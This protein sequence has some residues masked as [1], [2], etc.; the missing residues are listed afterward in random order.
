MGSQQ[1]RFQAVPVSKPRNYGV[2][3]GHDVLIACLGISLLFC[4]CEPE[5]ATG[6]ISSSNE[7]FTR[8]TK[9]VPKGTAIATAQ[10]FMEKE[11]FV[12]EPLT[13]AKWKGKEGFDYILCKR[14]DG[15]PRMKRLR[16]VAI[17][18][19]GKKVT[20]VDSRMPI[21]FP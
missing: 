13:K 12:C 11:G 9:L 3:R 4:G 19:D 6:E 18:H 5:P 1:M 20:A 16:E 17:F 2:I 8:I 21:G 7:M 15:P 10:E 14:E